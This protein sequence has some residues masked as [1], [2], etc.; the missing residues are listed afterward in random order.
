MLEPSQRERHLEAD[1]DSLRADCV[2][3]AN[4]IADERN[5]AQVV[6]SQK[7]I[8]ETINAQLLE[9]LEGMLTEQD[10]H[11]RPPDGAAVMTC[12]G[13]WAVEQNAREAIQKAK[14]AS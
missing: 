8:L 12:P 13:C 11:P 5:R 7:G 6:L 1:A 3:L 14:E 9:A 10:S 2:R 4:I